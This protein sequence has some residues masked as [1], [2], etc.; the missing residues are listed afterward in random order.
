MTRIDHTGHNHPATT[1]ARTECRNAITALI[2]D[3]NRMRAELPFSSWTLAGDCLR[4][5]GDAHATHGHDDNGQPFKHVH[6][7]DDTA[8]ASALIAKDWTWAKAC[9]MHS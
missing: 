9:W 3:Y 1:K 8:C 2:S 4:M 7:L 5:N 6:H